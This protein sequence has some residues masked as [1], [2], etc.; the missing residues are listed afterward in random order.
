MQYL[1]WRTLTRKHKST[2]FS[3]LMTGHT[4][5]IC[6]WIFGLVKRKLRKAKV[7]CL[8]DVCRAIEESASSNMSQ[9]CGTEKGDV[10]AP[11]YDWT[12]FLREFFK[13]RKDSKKFHH[14][15]FEASFLCKEFVD[16]RPK[17]FVCCLM[18]S[19]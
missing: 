18:G 10:L 14:F 12:S 8:E 19:I 17:A 3:F 9:L 6:D 16:S 11:M 4:K 13:K 1:L 5:F 7:D 15:S 2:E